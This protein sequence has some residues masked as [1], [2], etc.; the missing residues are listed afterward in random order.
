MY[1]EFKISTIYLN[2]LNVMHICNVIRFIAV[3]SSYRLG[4]HAYI[5][6]DS[7][8]L[9]AKLTAKESR[10]SSLRQTP[11]TM[12]C[13]QKDGGSPDARLRLA[14]LRLARL[15]LN[16]GAKLWVSFNL[17]FKT[18]NFYCTYWRNIL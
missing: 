8:L 1:H 11:F 2:S 9:T 3:C 5:L 15:R 16:D 4:I 17:C 7:S 18:N 13:N 10:E 12:I 6:P 14:R